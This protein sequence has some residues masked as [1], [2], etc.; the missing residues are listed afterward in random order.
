MRKGETLEGRDEGK[1]K[2]RGEEGVGLPF[3]LAYTMSDIPAS[4]T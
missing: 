4:L 1:E 3:I 2:G